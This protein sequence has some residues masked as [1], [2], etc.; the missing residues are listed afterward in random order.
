MAGWLGRMGH[1]PSA[2]ASPQRRLLG[3]LA[4]P[5]RAAVESIVAREGRP[6]AVIGHSRGGHFA[7]ALASRRPDLISQV[8]SMGAGLD[9]PFDISVPTQAAV[10]AVRGV[11]QAGSRKAA[12][13]G[14][15]DRHLRL[16]VRAG[17]R[18]AV[19]AGGAAHLDL[20]RGD[21]VVRWRA[22][23]V[24]YARNVE[25]TGSHIG[26]AFNRR[27]Y[28]VLGLLLGDRADEVRTATP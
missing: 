14:L 25:V 10:A 9:Q 12:A 7:K 24:P 27:V 20:R 11:L 22:C 1:H 8:V 28:R 16:P 5:A 15:P 13:R 17:L 26:L 18:R 3:P 4:G 6:A 19:P 2:R 21:G 23:V